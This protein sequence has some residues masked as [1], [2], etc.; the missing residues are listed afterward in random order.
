MRG[1]SYVE[2]LLS[3]T[4]LA[5]LL[6]PALEALQTAI[7]GRPT[8][9]A[10]PGSLALQSKMEEVLAA[11]FAK[12]YAETYLPGGNTP[13]SV[14]ATFSDAAGTPDRRL[15]VIHRY[16]AVTKTLSGVDTGL[17]FVNVYYEAE[18]PSSGLATLVG[19]WW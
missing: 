13:N 9:A 7:A 3:V 17:A 1:F 10:V 5:V 12:I 16:N 19:R 4:L 2:I 15:V 8:A 14:S 18:G 11:P 6:V